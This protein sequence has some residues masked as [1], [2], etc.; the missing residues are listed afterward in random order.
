MKEMAMNGMQ[1]LE[2]AIVAVLF[3]L[4]W[5]AIVLFFLNMPPTKDHHHHRR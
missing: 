2:I 4:G 1:W 3:G 5:L